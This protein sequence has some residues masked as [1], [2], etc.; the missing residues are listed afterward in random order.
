MKKHIALFFILLTMF[1]L[2][3]CNKL[4]WPDGK[5]GNMIPQIENAKGEIGHEDLNSLYIKLEGISEKQFLEYIESCKAKGFSVDSTEDNSSYTA[6]TENGY[7]IN[8]VFFSSG[9]MWITVDAPISMTTFDWP[10][11]DI[12]KLLPKPSSNYGKIEWEA[13]YGFVIYVGNTSKADYKEYVDSVY[14]L[15]FTVDY[16]KGDNYF[17]ADNGEGYSISLKYEGFNTMWIRIDEPE[18]NT[19]PETND[20]NN[21]SNNTS[22]NNNNNSNNGSNND[23]DNTENTNAPSS[24]EMV[25]GMRREFKDAMDSYETFFD[26]YCNFMKKYNSSNDTSSMLNDYLSFMS[27]YTETMNKLDALGDDNLN[28]AELRYYTEVMTRINQKLLEVS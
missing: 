15:G 12:A 11:S 20:S 13:D 21:N 28:T 25:N 10:D 6:F 14:A 22:N 24:G 26:E 17:Y 2:V 8:I 16:N 3:S 23:K 27:R 4:D 7:K 9:D 18:E 1:A 5:L 19:V